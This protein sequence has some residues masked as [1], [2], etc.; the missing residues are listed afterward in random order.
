MSK[1]MPES[2]SPLEQ[3]ICQLLTSHAESMGPNVKAF[4]IAMQLHENSAEEHRE[5]WQASKN[6]MWIW[7]CISS[8]N[9][10][11]N[12]CRPYCPELARTNLIGP[13]PKWVTDYLVESALHLDHLAL[14]RHADGREQ[15]SASK[16]LDR[17]PEILRLTRP[18]YN[19]VREYRADARAAELVATHDF[20]SAHGRKPLPLAAHF[21]TEERPARRR[22]AHL[23]KLNAGEP[24]RKG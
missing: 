15:H 23:R 10:V 16:V 1:C 8:L 6:P 9:Y 2:P 7:A 18:G 17:L 20:V 3:A 4:D 11:C 14:K 22:I 21:R 19:A 5:K 13:L 12:L 24:L